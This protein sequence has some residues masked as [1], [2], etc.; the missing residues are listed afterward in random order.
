MYLRDFLSRSPIRLTWC[1][2]LHD[3]WRLENLCTCLGNKC[4]R[5]SHIGQSLGI[6]RTSIPMPQW[7]F[8]CKKFVLYLSL[9][10]L[11]ALTNPLFEKILVASIGDIL[12]G[13]NHWWEGKLWTHDSTVMLVFVMD[14]K[15]W[16]MSCTITCMLMDY[17]MIW[18]GIHAWSSRCGCD[19]V[20]PPLS[21]LDHLL[22]SAYDS[23][24]GS[25][26]IQCHGWR[27]VKS[28]AQVLPWSPDCFSFLIFDFH[29][30]P[31]HVCW[32]VSLLYTSQQITLVS[33]YGCINDFSAWLLREEAFASV[34]I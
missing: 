31:C 8:Q 29:G 26:C 6:A 34:V 32:L 21:L 15:T 16:G 14:C 12:Y 17:T 33:Q 23:Y 22:P 11:I 13:L 30:Y 19:I 25:N 3:Y 4:R 7:L 27:H 1:I 18:Q 24:D 2:H 5:I 28:S 10:A 20:M 9:F